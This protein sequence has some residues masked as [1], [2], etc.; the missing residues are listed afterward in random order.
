MRRFVSLGDGG[1]LNLRVLIGLFVLLAGIF[2]AFFAMSA[3]GPI[4]R[5]DAYSGRTPPGKPSSC[6]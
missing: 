3:T 5:G 4:R 1:F 6:S 2:L